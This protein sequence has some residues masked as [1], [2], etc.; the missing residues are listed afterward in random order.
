M[1]MNSSKKTLTTQGINSQYFLL[2]ILAISGLAVSLYLTGLYMDVKFPQDL[3]SAASVCDINKWFNCDSSTLSPVSNIFGLPISALGSLFMLSLIGSCIFPARTWERTNH[4]LAWLNVA[5]CVVLFLYTL[6]FLKSIC[7]FCSLYWLISVGI[8]L[9]FW[10]R[11]ESIGS[12]DIKVGTVLGML[13][14][15]VI[16]G[17]SFNIRGKEKTDKRLA[18]SLFQQFQK[19]PTLEEPNSPN[20]IHLSTEKFADAP[21][22]ISEFSDFQCPSCKVFAELI[23][24]FIK[25]YAGKLNMQYVFYPLDHNCNDQ[26]ERPFHPLACQ[27]AYLSHCAKEKFHTVHD[28]IFA[29]QENLSQKWIDQKASELGIQNCL[30]D[31][32]TIA[33]VKEQIASGTELGISSTPTLIVNGK[34]ITAGLNLRQ[35]YLLFDEIIKRR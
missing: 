22:R 2:L 20:Y 19:Q 14:L 8:A 29:N 15:I 21:L 10:K 5:G 18:Y 1:P 16:G 27:A 35:F 11:G 9:L 13:A 23:P 3:G 34:K 24:K 17:Y 6:F 26:I 30:K 12:P 28:E 31:P 25:R 4:S 7:P 32:E 33:A